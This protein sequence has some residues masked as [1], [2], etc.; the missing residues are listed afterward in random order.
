[1][2]R[3][4]I[5]YVCFYDTP[6]SLENRSYSPAAAQK[7]RYIA[8]ALASTGRTVH[9]ISGS[10]TRGNAYQR[11][12]NEL[13][14]ERI[15]LKK[16]SSWGMK[17]RLLRQLPKLLF[18][19][20]LFWYLLLQI[21]RD[22]TVIV[23]HSLY[24][25]RM[26]RM[27]KRL[28]HFRLIYEVEEIYADVDGNPS[29]R[30]KE[31]E[32]ICVGDAYL[33][34]TTALRDLVDVHGK[35]SVIIHGTYFAQPETPRTDDGI[36]HCVYAGTLDP[37]KGGAALAV[38][39]AAALP[40]NYHIHIL[41]FGSEEK[42]REIRSLIEAVRKKN[43]AA[44][45]YD[46]VLLGEEYIR[47]LERC[48]IGLSTQQPDA[49]FNA[50]SFPSKILSYLACGLQVVTIR[51]PV[52]EQSDVGDVLY[53]YEEPTPEALAE[54]ILRVDLRS[55][56]SGCVVIRALDEKFKKELAS[57]LEQTEMS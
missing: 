10:Q 26:I 6:D 40:A 11:G 53:Y 56:S 8:Q 2:Q 3:S 1:M 33:F 57:L 7:T 19:L 31:L 38:R 22:D 23:Y 21:G 46:G 55:G 50:S 16:F 14:E 25:M 24:Y 39:A 17:N 15:F 34:P 41:G 37:R 32:N 9:L 12:S 51:I 20:R 48:H 30:E 47:F 36:V 44:V 43:G 18:R 45:S 49:A 28:K 52:V 27:L 5:L 13:L 54:A 4:N 42:V 29:L 35:P